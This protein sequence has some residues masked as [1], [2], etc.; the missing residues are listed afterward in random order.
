MVV[1]PRRSAEQRSGYTLNGV[2]PV[3]HGR[4][5][6]G[7]HGDGKGP[8]VP[9]DPVDLVDELTQGGGLGTVL[10]IGLIAKRPGDHRHSPALPTHDCREQKPGVADELRGIRE[11][12]AKKKRA[13]SAGLSNAVPHEPETEKSVIPAARATAYRPASPT[14]DQHWG[15]GLVI[16]DVDHRVEE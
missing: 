11:S 9:L 1:C 15:G 16:R 5:A 8:P 10:E 3:L 2:D 12:I 4:I 13:W 6:V 14:I 7:H